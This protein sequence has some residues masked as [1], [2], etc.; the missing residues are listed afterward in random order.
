M[1]S[2]DGVEVD[3]IDI[4]PTWMN[5]IL[6]CLTTENSLIEKSEAQR[7]KF[8]ATRCHVINGILY[9][10]GYTLL[11]LQCIHPPHV[12]GILQEIHEGV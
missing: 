12:K 6:S 3:P 4:G 8:K 5:P 2:L 10:R 9:K 11:Y 1:S 7:V